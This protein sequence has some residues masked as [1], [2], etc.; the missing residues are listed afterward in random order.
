[1]PTTPT[2]SIWMPPWTTAPGVTFSDLSGGEAGNPPFKIIDSASTGDI[3]L[4][5]TP[6]NETS[7]NSDTDDAGVGSQ[8]IIV[9]EPDQG[10]RIDFGQFTSHPNSG[11]TSDDGFT[12]DEHTSVN[13]FK[14]TIDQIS[15]GTTADVLI[16]IYD[17]NEG[18]PNQS[19]INT[20]PPGGLHDFTDDTLLD[21][22]SVSIYNT[23]GGLVGTATGDTTFGSI[24]VDFI[25][26][27]TVEITGLPAQ[28]SIETTGVTD[29]DR[30]E[31]LN[32]GD[33]ST[34][35]G[36][37]SVSNLELET[38]NTGD[39]IDLSLDIIGTDEDGDFVTSS[40][41]F[42]VLPDDASSIIGT[43]GGE[44]LPGTAGDD[45]IAGLAGADN[46]IGGDGEDIL[47]GGLGSDT[48]WGGAQGVTTGDGFD[49][50][51]VINDTLSID[52]IEDYVLNAGVEEDQV[53]LTALFTAD[54]GGANPDT[55][56]LSD[57]V[58]IVENGAGAVDELQV[59]VDGGGD[60]FQTVALL[61]GNGGVK[62]LFDD[63]GTDTSGTV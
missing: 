44:T 1:M 16:K 41:D 56:Q 48:L 2:R 39:P 9:A 17:A 61:D 14:F 7:I 49:D 20:D 34:T 40:L 32:S 54:I 42:T 60:N 3:E 26:D 27:G 19:P 13:G 11:G 33:P 22:Q 45:F 50:T 30:I 43:S 57:F 29:Y 38:V 18:V 53:D 37:F 62:I 31:I 5:F 21:I 58:Q 6:I 23:L 46:L 10:L 25:G 36:K 24:G 15:Q 8:F 55:D 52:T 28:Y 59:D 35:D 47:A 12:I 4:L 63:N 51:F